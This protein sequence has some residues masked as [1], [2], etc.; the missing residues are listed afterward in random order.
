M[1]G[2]RDLST[3]LLGGA[4]RIESAHPMS[5]RFVAEQVAPRGYFVSSFA[6]VTAFDSDA[7]LVLV[8]TGSFMLVERTRQLLRSVVGSPAHTAL[9]THGT[10]ITCSASSSTSARPGARSA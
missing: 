3:Q 9:W 4:I 2:L 8:D 10:S 6:N 5:P 1:A 7:G